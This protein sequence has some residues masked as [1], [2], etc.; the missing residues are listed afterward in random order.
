MGAAD[1]ASTTRFDELKSGDRITVEQTVTV[2]KKKQ[3][4][5]TTG[6]VIRTERTH[7]SLYHEHNV[8]N[9]GFR[10]TILL[11]LPDGELT[12]VIMDEFTMLH[13]A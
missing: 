3:T 6:T 9:S 12:T 7:S 2:E 11:E 1:R 8:D 4:V 10:D 5:A 13:R